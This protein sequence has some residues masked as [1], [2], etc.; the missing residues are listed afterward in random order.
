[1]AGSVYLS[2]ISDPPPP[3]VGGGGLLLTITETT[4][5]PVVPLIPAGLLVPAGELRIQTGLQESGPAAD[6]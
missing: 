3:L 6:T 2:I 4:Q 1:M 5:T